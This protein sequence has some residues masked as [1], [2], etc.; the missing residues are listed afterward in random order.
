MAVAYNGK[1]ASAN[2]GGSTPTSASWSH[3]ATGDNYLVVAISFRGLVSSV[4]GTYNSVSLMQLGTVAPG[5]LAEVYLF[6]LASPSTGSNTISFSWTGAAFWGGVSSSY[7]GVISTGTVQTTSSTTTGNSDLTVTATLTANDL[8][9]AGG[10]ADNNA[11][12]LS[13]TTGTLLDTAEAGPN[14][15]TTIAGYNTG[16]GSTSVVMHIVAGDQQ[17]LI[18]VPLIGASAAATYIPQLLTSHVG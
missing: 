15:V 4:T 13:I 3:D 11:A 10:G 7:S 8:F 5:T 17:G 2:S 6:G 1:K 18:G 12:S 16:T 14:A 9:S